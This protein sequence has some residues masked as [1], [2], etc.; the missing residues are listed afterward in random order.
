MLQ[1]TLPPKYRRNAIAASILCFVW[2]A[3]MI[4]ISMFQIANTHSVGYWNALVAIGYVG[5]GVGLLRP[6]SAARQWAAASSFANLLF[7][8]LG[9]FDGFVLKDELAV[10]VMLLLWLIQGLILLF[11]IKSRKRQPSSKSIWM[12]L[13]TGG[14][15]GLVSEEFCGPESSVHV[16]GKTPARKFMRLLLVAGITVVAFAVLLVLIALYIRSGN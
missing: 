14:V 12:R 11:V 3:L 7:G 1:A 5:I 4:P 9:V 6:G 16:P 2:A 13:A 10:A 8:A 15:L